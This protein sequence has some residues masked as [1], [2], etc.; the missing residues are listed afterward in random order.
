[1]NDWP[2]LPAIV[3]GAL[4]S[5]AQSV[6]A[7]AFGVQLSFLVPAACNLF[8]IYYGLKYGAMYQR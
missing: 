5:L 2:R 8:V 1:M 6:L 7:D 3:G 4:V